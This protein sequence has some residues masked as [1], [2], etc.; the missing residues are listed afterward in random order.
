MRKII[1]AVASVAILAASMVH[2]AP[3]FAV[4]APPDMDKPCMQYGCKRVPDGTSMGQWAN[5]CAGCFQARG[6]GVVWG[7][8]QLYER[9]PNGTWLMMAGFPPPK[10]EA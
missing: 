10:N 9:T 6:V 3:S 1:Q 5:M 4:M 2:A 8:G 7:S